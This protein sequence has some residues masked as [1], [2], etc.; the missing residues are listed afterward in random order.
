MEYVCMM[1]TGVG[2]GIEYVYR[3]LNG[4]RVQGPE[5]NACALYRVRVQGTEWITCM[6]CL[7]VQDTIWS[8]Y[9]GYTSV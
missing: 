6:G 4:I 8:V 9:T 2:Y 3:V 5:W 1:D 7:Y